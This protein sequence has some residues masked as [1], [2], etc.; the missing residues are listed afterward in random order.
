MKDFERVITAASERLE[1]AFEKLPSAYFVDKDA[2]TFLFNNVEQFWNH[3]PRDHGA[4]VADQ[5]S[6][7]LSNAS[8][9]RLYFGVP[10]CD[11]ICSFCNF[12]YSTSKNSDVHRAYLKTIRKELSLL[13]DLGLRE[14][15]VSSVYFGGGTPTVLSDDN[16]RRYLEVMLSPLRLSTNASVTCESTPAALTDQK[17]R[18]MVDFGVTRLSMGIQSLD[19]RVREQA[20]LIG[21]REDVL[22]RAQSAM[23][24]FDMVNLDLIYGYPYQTNAGW[25]DTVTS[26]ASLNP[27]SI[28]VYRLEVK[29]RTHNLKLYQKEN[30]IFE[31]ELDARK[32]YF[33]AAEVLETRGYIQSPLG[34]WVRGDKNLTS[35]SWKEHMRGWTNVTPYIGLGQGAWS[36]ATSNHYQ[37]FEKLG[38]WMKAIE[39]GKLPIKQSIQMDEKT[40]LLTFIARVF[41]SL[42][43]IDLQSADALMRANR[44]HERVKAF[45]DQQVSFGLLESEDCCYRLT[46]GGEALVHWV[47]RDLIEAAMKE[48]AI[49]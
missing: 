18:L 7:D 44:I 15:T 20:N 16:F 41:R 45:V 42:K 29:S 14:S 31:D 3:L 24:C 9:S 30:E 6:E 28:T 4:E 5:L 34:W 27:Q 23:E 48:N 35:G 32:K 39:V 10:W 13:F 40:Q 17:L 2:E 19:S 46:D 8:S 1:S 12:A 22:L 25:Y 33:I 21:S 49:P 37:N 36:Q 43:T 38:D 11:K 26:I 47:L